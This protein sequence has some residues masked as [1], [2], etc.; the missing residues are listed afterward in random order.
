M[1]RCPPGPPAFDP[2]GRLQ[3]PRLYSVRP[4]IWKAEAWRSRLDV[5]IGTP[6]VESE[7]SPTQLLWVST[8]V[9]WTPY[10]RMIGGM[11]ESHGI[12]QACFD[13]FKRWQ[14]KQ[15]LSQVEADQ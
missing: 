12:L 6:T 9:S 2:S 1:S 8:C 13:L 10:D 11:A 15:Q 14:I 7:L 4:C 3:P 5:T